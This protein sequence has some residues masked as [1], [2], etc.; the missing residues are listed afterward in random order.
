MNIESNAY[1]IQHKLRKMQQDLSSRSKESGAKRDMVRC[2][3]NEKR[4]DALYIRNKESFAWLTAGGSNG[5]VL[6]TQIGAAS[7]LL[8]EESQ[9]VIASNIET[10]RLQEE[11]FLKE[12]GFEIIT[13]NWMGQSDYDIALSL[14][15]SSNIYSDLAINQ[16]PNVHNDLISL[17][18]SLID[19]EIIRYRFL[20]I[21]SSLILEQ[22]METLHPGMSELEIIALLSKNLWAV[23]IEPINLLCAVDERIRKYRHPSPTQKR[24]EHLCM[25]S[26]GARYSGLVVSLTRT[27]SFGGL[28]DIVR[29]QKKASDSVW[30]KMIMRTCLDNPVSDILEA[31][32][33]SYKQAGYPKEYLQ[34][35][36]GG[37]IGYLPREYKVTPTS[38]QIVQRKSRI[39]LESNNRWHKD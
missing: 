8:T 3:M 11:E 14:A 20:G 4:M 5:G 6:S 19:D 34:H 1:T 9:Y 13:T 28:P 38:T 7:I 12:L 17:R 36:Q 31:G 10:P 26:L 21:L 22:T 23:G 30:E 27:V 39:L 18:Y 35:H 37:A 33:L 25:V 29:E 24:L 15:P 32:I 2:L 16:S